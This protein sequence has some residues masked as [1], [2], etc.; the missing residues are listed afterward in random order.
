MCLHTVISSFFG[1]ANVFPTGNEQYSRDPF[2]TG[3]QAEMVTIANVLFG[4]E[5]GRV[6]V[7]GRRGM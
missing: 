4:G 2:D 1:F 5:L 3:Y 6:W 7:A